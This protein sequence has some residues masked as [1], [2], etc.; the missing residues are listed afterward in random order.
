MTAIYI[1]KL[2]HEEV[3]AL[4]ELFEV[5]PLIP[6]QEK[7]EE[8]FNKNKTDEMLRTLIKLNRR[9]KNKLTEF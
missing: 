9:V 1:M 2:T 4:R 3:E 8:T 7:L 6:L 5:T